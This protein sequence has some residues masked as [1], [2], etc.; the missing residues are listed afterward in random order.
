[1]FL[2]QEDSREVSRRYEIAFPHGR[3]AHIV[4][5]HLDSSPISIINTLDLAPP[6]A[7]IV[8]N[9]GTAVLEDGLQTQMSQLLQDG[10]ARIASEEGITLITGGTAA[11]VFAVLG[12]GWEAWRQTA[13][14]IG[15]AVAN[16]VT[17][18]G[19]IA[20]GC[21]QGRVPLESHH[22]H[23]VLTGGSKWGDETEVMYALVDALRR[24]RRT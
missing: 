12:M 13:P 6:R 24:Y 16:L 23:F 14:C 18:P 3:F 11:G 21:D 4:Y 20:H 15:V 10:I 19:R 22:S 8:L 1:M 2:A 9:G 7:L 5:A 17:W